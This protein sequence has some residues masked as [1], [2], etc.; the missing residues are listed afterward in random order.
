MPYQAE[1]K[2]QW[3]QILLALADGPRH[4]LGIR[5]EVLRQTDGRMRLWPAMLYGSLRR[6]EEDG[7]IAETVA[8]GPGSETD[9]RRFYKI[10]RNGRRALGAETAALAAYVAVA[11]TK[12]VVVP[13]H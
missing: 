5:D 3:Y 12:N 8:E 13:E 7:L 1:I 10:S 2:P 6:M 11:K 9:R 4:G